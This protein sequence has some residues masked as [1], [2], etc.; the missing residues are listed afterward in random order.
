M[1]LHLEI[2]SSKP[3]EVKTE[4]RGLEKREREPKERG[5][6]LAS[7]STDKAGK[8]IKDQG[9]NLDRNFVVR[10]VHRK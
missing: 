4:T 8:S 3:I 5:R 6:L 7:E 9:T 10:T 1:F 2:G